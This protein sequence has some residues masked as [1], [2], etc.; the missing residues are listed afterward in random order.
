MTCGQF[1][2]LLTGSAQ[3]LSASGPS[4]THHGRAHGAAGAAGGG[5]RGAKVAAEHHPNGSSDGWKMAGT[6][7][8]MDET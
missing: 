7:G 8:K 2:H 4:P 6:R 1:L 5:L 3:R